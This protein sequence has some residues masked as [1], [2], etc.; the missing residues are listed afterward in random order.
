M[1]E[2]IRHRQN[3]VTDLQTLEMEFGAEI[4][5]RSRDNRLILSHDPFAPGDS[6]EEFLAGYAKTHS[7][8]LLIVNTKEDGHEKAIL[9]LLAKYAVHHFFL[10]DTVL[11]TLVNLAV[12]Y[13]ERRAA[14]RVSEYEPVEMSDRFA[15]LVE[16]IWLD[17]FKG[18]P[19]TPETVRHLQKS[20]KVCLVSPEL[21]GYPVDRIG[22]FKAILPGVQA[23]CTKHPELW[24]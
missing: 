14:V 8:R 21:Q 18:S 24:V 5:V 10:L 17:C 9:A 12:K 1:L 20:F 13:H 7:Q 23:V 6:F 11:P 19:P 3:L 16:W 22:S 4:D 2:I 15:G